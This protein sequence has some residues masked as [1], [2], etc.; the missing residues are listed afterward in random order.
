M[1]FY[2][3]QPTVQC[4]FFECMYIIITVV[5]YRH[6]IMYVFSLCVGDY[7]LMIIYSLARTMCINILNTH[8]KIVGI[9]TYECI[10]MYSTN[11]PQLK[12]C[13]HVIHMPFTWCGCYY[14]Y[15]CVYICN[16]TCMHTHV[17]PLYTCVD[18][19][20]LYLVICAYLSLF[21]FQWVQT[22]H[23]MSI[24]HYDGIWKNLT[25]WPSFWISHFCNI[26]F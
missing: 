13:I 14:C 20:L 19:Y 3:P 12:C 23:S 4:K 6:N 22:F 8:L 24:S 1:F 2:P 25:Q 11:H 17:H 21:T 7:K 10:C 9:R 26:V 15:T 16:V 18:M 5:F